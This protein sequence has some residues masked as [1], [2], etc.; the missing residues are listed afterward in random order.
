MALQFDCDLCVLG[1]NGI[2]V[3]LIRMLRVFVQDPTMVFVGMQDVDAR[4]CEN[5]LRKFRCF[6]YAIRLATRECSKHWRW[7]KGTSSPNM[8]P[9]FF[10]M[11]TG[12]SPEI[13][14][15]AKRGYI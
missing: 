9:S 6:P 13:A 14:L 10:N 11:L 12:L 3:W 15:I 1:I 4:V 7:R 2:L 5:M 8:F